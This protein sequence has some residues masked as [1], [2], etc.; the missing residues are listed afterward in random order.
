M[1]KHLDLR[2]FQNHRKLHIDFGKITTITGCS[3]SGKS[4]IIRAIQWLCFN[5][6]R[7]SSFITHGQDKCLVSVEIA[8][9]GSV[10]RIKTPKRNS[11]IF[12]D[13]DRDA[14]GA[15]TGGTAASPL[16]MLHVC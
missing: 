9:Y 10:S 14:V 4:A 7:G 8:D 5:N 11:Y 6:L 1:L 2:N 13:G 3:D 15:D 16:A 12:E